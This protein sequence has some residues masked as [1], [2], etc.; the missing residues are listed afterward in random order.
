MTL[1]NVDPSLL[2]EACLRGHR[3]WWFSRTDYGAWA[4]CDGEVRRCQFV[5]FIGSK[6]AEDETAMPVAIDGFSTAELIR[7]VREYAKVLG[8]FK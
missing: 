4:I 3:L 6:A 1:E 7:L 5:W 2:P 8:H